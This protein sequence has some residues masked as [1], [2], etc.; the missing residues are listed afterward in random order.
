MTITEILKLTPSTSVNVTVVQE[1]TTSSSSDSIF[2]DPLTPIGFAAEINQCYHSEENVCDTDDADRLTKITRE[3]IAARNYPRNFSSQ[4]LDQKAKLG[5]L[6]ISNIDKYDIES[7]IPEEDNMPLTALRS[8]IPDS[9]S[10]NGI[11]E[12]AVFNVA[13]V[14]KVELQDLSTKVLDGDGKYI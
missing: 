9:K 14:K 4:V 2:T 3:A 8:K 11:S 1:Q 10:D 12:I 7:T 6:S 13:R 5:Q